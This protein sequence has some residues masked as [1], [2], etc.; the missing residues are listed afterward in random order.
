MQS[1][2][3]QVQAYT[4]VVGRL[5]TGMLAADPDALDPPMS[6]TR[7]GATTGLII[8]VLLC[9][10]FLIFGMISPGESTAWRKPGTLIMEK[11]TGARYVFGGGVLRPVVNY[12][13]GKL[14]TGGQGEMLS[15]GRASLADVP[16]GAPI[17]I[18]GAPD[19]LP[20][21][22]GLSDHAWQVCATSRTAADGSTESTTTVGVA[23]A[24]TTPALR[25]DQALPATG[26]DGVT[27]LLWQ[28]KRLRLD[29]AHG[30]LQSLGYGTAD[31]VRVGSAFLA[32]V[33]AGPDLAPQEVEGRGETGPQLAGEK[34]RVGQLFDVRTPGSPDQHYLLG[35]DGL[36]PLTVTGAQL[37]HGDPRTAKDAY[38]GKEAAATVLGPDEV[39][40][41]L[42]PKGG[43][44]PAAGLPAA[45]PKAVTRQAGTVPCL[46]VTPQGGTPDQQLTQVPVRYAVGQPAAER[47]G[48]TAGCPAPELIGA[49]PGFGVLAEPLPSGAG[50]G[51]L[52]LVTGEGVKYPL[53]SADAAKRLSYDGVKPV[54]LPSAL[55]RLLPTGPALDPARAARP[56][57]AGP[58]AKPDPGCANAAAAGKGVQ[59]G[60]TPG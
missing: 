8:G 2:R 5:T 46:R 31:P 38:G 57:D 52:Y 44:G 40:A 19:S 48:V 49:R 50:S 35:R 29:S 14:V 25:S 36:H 28:G 22:A 43:A 6:R 10:G 20:D 7:R 16:R 34:R 18:P 45:P 17:G 53:A 42:A 13:S 24:A 60:G 4:F 15:V 32:A 9:V 1:R 59:K 51:T 41:H 23:A 27:Y 3:D 58:A 30:A 12:A 37:L 54:R 47:D 56:A 26:P 55:L 21:S 39:R 33:P 11:E